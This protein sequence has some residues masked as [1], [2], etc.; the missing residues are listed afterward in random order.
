MASLSVPAIAVSGLDDGI[1][2]AAEAVAAWVVKFAQSELV[3]NLKK[4]QYL[5]ASIPALPFDQ[6]KGVRLAKRA[7]MF[8]DFRFINDEKDQGLWLLKPIPL[9]P[10]LSEESDL[11]LYNAG[12][13]AVVPMKLDEH[14]YELYER[15]KLNPEMLKQIGFKR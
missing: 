15:I 9:K 14:D 6:I 10:D 4:G 11:S 3:R 1:P 12:Y 13:I 8:V 2:G 7:G 5:T